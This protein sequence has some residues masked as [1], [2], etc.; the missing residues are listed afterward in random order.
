MSNERE[1]SLDYFTKTIIVILSL[2]DTILSMCAR[3]KERYEYIN[4]YVWNMGNFFNE[5]FSLSLK[6]TNDAILKSSVSWNWFTITN[7]LFLFDLLNFFLPL[8]IFLFVQNRDQNLI[9][10]KYFLLLSVLMIKNSQLNTSFR[11][12]EALS[13]LLLIF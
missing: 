12:N 11:F 2:I 9:F 13:F 7:I 4:I 5:F 3:L 10:L 6:R 8:L 1:R